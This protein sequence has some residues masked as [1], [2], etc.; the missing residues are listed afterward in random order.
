[1]KFKIEIEDDNLDSMEGSI[2]IS[3]EDTKVLATICTMF[4]VNHSFYKLMKDAIRTQEE[5]MRHKIHEM[6]KPT[7]EA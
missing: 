7:A 1:M 3:G 4:C 5:F 2:Q 6:K